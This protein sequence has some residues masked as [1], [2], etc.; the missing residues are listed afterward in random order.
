MVEAHF[1]EINRLCQVLAGMGDKIADTDYATIIMG[2]LPDSYRSII[3]SLEAATGYASKVVTL[4]ELIT[5]VTVEYEHR[6]IRNPQSTRKGG[7]ATLTAGT[8]ERQGRKATK[9]TVCF[10]CEKKGH[11]KSDCW[12]KGGGK[13]GQRP[14]GQGRR[15][16]KKETA[17]AAV[18]TPAPPQENYAFSASA[19]ANVGRRGAI[20]DSG[21]HE[22]RL[23]TIIHSSTCL[24]Q[25]VT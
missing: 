11:F 17:S 10:N 19:P 2:S 4:Q 18:S 15:N 24:N 16:G 1:G 14:A 7:N 6:L 21:C 12:A 8:S 9:D 25:H 22:F 23:Q 13:E 5:T 3:S 20:I